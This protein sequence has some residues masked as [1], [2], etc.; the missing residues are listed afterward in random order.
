MALNSAVD[1]KSYNTVVIVSGGDR[2]ES[3]YYF[4]SSPS[5]STSALPPVNRRLT[6]RLDHNG[7]T[8]LSPCL[9]ASLQWSAAEVDLTGNPLHCDCVLLQAVSGWRHLHQRDVK[10]PRVVFT[11]AQCASPSNRAE[12][13]LNRYLLAWRKPFYYFNIVYM[14]FAVSS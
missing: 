3:D 13:Y 10:A 11:G 1:R 7:M 6:L 5:S 9:P 12:I 14:L 4:L 2:N 8:S